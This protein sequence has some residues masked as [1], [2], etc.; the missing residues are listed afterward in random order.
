M[1]I[2]F[3][4]DITFSVMKYIYALIYGPKQ[5]KYII[6]YTTNTNIND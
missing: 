5:I 1:L 2:Q 3:T 6:K 4:S